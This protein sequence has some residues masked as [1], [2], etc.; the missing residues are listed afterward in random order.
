MKGTRHDASPARVETSQA[1]LE[2]LRA[3]L[4]ACVTAHSRITKADAERIPT[5][6]LATIAFGIVPT[7]R[8]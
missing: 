5:A 4:L 8:C 7:G 3:R 6:D 1:A 2:A